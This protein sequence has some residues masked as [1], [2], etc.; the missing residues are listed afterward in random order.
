MELCKKEEESHLVPPW[1]EGASDDSVGA[2]PLHDAARVPLAGVGV[3][4]PC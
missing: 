3:Q 4:G 2:E 1:Y